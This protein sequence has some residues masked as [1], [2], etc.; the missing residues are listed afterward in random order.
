[1]LFRSGER[2]KPATARDGSRIPLLRTGFIPSGVYTVSF[3]Y[4]NAGPSFSKRGDYSMQLPK[5]DIPVNLLTWEVSLPDRLEVRRFGGNALA[6]ELFPAAVQTLIIDDSELGEA[7]SERFDQNE[8][9][10]A[11]LLPGQIGGIVVDPAG[12]VV[13]GAD[14][15]LVNKQSGATIRTKS[16]ADGRWVVTNM[17]AGPLTVS[18]DSPGF[19]SSKQDLDLVA[20]QPGLLGTTLEVGT[21]AETVTVQSGATSLNGLYKIDEQAR[22][23]QSAQLNAPSQNLLNLQRRVAGVLPVKVDVPKAGTSYR[24]VR[25]LVLDEETT[26]TFQYRSR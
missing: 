11:G 5:L 14:I 19:K 16:N 7:Y 17:P 4:L 24:F 23:N 25:P 22:R 21:V 8:I 20:S 15:S 26:I 12:S 13:A 9:D 2:V 18:V 3:V 1:M 10:I 6:A